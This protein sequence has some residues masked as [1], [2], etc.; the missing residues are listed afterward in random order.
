MDVDL[1]KS[2]DQQ[3]EEIVVEDEG[4]STALHHVTFQK[5]ME[6]LQEQLN[7]MSKSKF[8]KSI[9]VHFTCKSKQE[10]SE[11]VQHYEKRRIVLKKQLQAEK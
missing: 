5:T 2:Y 9:T 10:V 1:F 4:K 11:N 3:F 7:E 8:Y 6:V